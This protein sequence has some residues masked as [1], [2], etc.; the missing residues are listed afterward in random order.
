MHAPH[1]ASVMTD[2]T[3]VF[4][5]VD[6]E[7]VAEAGFRPT[8][9]SVAF[10]VGVVALAA[11]FAHH[12]ASG[13]GPV[14]LGHEPTRIDWLFALSALVAARYVVLPV[15]R[16]P[17]AARRLWRTLRERPGALASAAY[18]LALVAL[19]A[20]EPVVGSSG[21]FDL[22]HAFQPPA[23]TSVSAS[24]PPECVGAVR[25][26]Q[27]YG[28]LVHPFGTNAFGESV[29]WSLADGAQVTLLVGLLTATLIV[30]LG[31]AVGTVA[32]YV[33]GWLDQTLMRYV[34]VQ[35][36]VPAFVVYMVLSYVVG[37]D[38]FVVV[39]VFGLLGWGGV[40]RVVRSDTL[41]HRSAAY[42][43][44]AEGAGASTRHVVRR[45]LLPGVGGTVATAVTRQI[46]LLVL[47]EAALSF[48]KLTDVEPRS[49]GRLVALGLRDFHQAWWP[50]TVPVAALALTVVAISVVGDALGDALDPRQ[51]TRSDRNRD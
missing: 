24:T 17:R 9:S 27:C 30:P 14:A 41:Q 47:A 26:G 11:V 51:E 50:S 35:Q 44:A 32:G 6:W 42:V 4:E 45:H 8:P 2:G 13:G 29:L 15:A 21:E 7:R 36:A 43:R 31:T 48:L 33:G 39:A 12:Y 3:A 40:A 34:D 5:R 23:F 38:L 49:F 20:L 18:L 16:D 1:Q 46:P 19:V 37:R 10:A 22:V 28:T 25:D